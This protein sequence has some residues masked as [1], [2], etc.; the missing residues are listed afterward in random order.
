[1]V[2]EGAEKDAARLLESLNK[3]PKIRRQLVF[4][5]R[6]GERRWNIK[7]NRGITVKLPERGVTNAFRIL[8]EISD[9]NG[10]FK[11]EIATIDLRIPDRVIITKTTAAHGAPSR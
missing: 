7:I 4:A 9:G 11:E 2:G 10:F 3:F 6:V 1:V 5:V 8:E